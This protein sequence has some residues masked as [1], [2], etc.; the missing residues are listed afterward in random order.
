[1]KTTCL[2]LLLSG[3]V[4]L[5]HASSASAVSSNSHAGYSAGARVSHKTYSKQDQTAPGSTPQTTDDGSLPGSS[6]PQVTAATSQLL[7]SVS[8][9]DFGNV[10]IG[11]RGV[12]AVTLTNTG[13]DTVAISDVS[14][15]GPGFD[16]SG[17]SAGA[18]LDAGQ[19]VRLTVTFSPSG[20]GRVSGNV[21]VASTA[22][23]PTTV[24]N[25]SGV[26]AQS[27][28]ISIS[29]VPAD[30]TISVGDKLQFKAV[31]NLGNDITSSVLW[32]SS[33][34][35]MV[36]ITPNGL[37]TA[38]ADGPVTIAAALGTGAQAQQITGST[39]LT[40]AT[41][42]PS[43]AGALLSGAVVTSDAQNCASS[44]I[45]AAVPAGWKMLCARGFEVSLGPNEALN[46]SNGPNVPGGVSTAQAH[47]GNHSLGCTVAGD[48][49]ECEWRLT[50]GTG[51]NEIYISYWEWFTGGPQGT[52]A[53]STDDEFEGGIVVYPGARHQD[54]RFDPTG[55]NNS[56]YFS[57]GLQPVF[58]SEGSS[59]S[60]ACY[61]GVADSATNACRE[62]GHNAT[63]AV[64]NTTY[65]STSTGTWV[66]W[67]LDLLPATCNGSTPNS[68]G[69]MTV[70]KNG[71]SVEQVVDTN[72][73]GGL[74]PNSMRGDPT[75]QIFAGGYQGIVWFSNS[76]GQCVDRHDPTNVNQTNTDN[77]A[78]IPALEADGSTPCLGSQHNFNRHLDDIIVL[79]K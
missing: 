34:P 37:A 5:I 58:Y 20:N 60:S 18:I 56:S 29:I 49:S 53:V 6:T 36:E 24:I 35:S 46:T 64:Q 76:G 9:F 33:D 40:V 71:Q 13:G 4:P 17:I 68:D 59:Y 70:Y 77:W 10:N 1:M 27:T 2:V 12:L 16:A 43:S 19:S 63:G 14:V 54:L 72:F 32:T 39:K 21:T 62:D 48:G 31:D 42:A 22:E 38:V 26:G 11:S 55:E 52:Q 25:L 3:I 73:S 61:G 47:S 7:G 50:P 67:E 41:A 79:T 51:A 57:Q 28:S 44:T 8:N 30:Q 66:Q 69:R 78:N 75:V 45:S 15:S 23:N 74:C 65:T